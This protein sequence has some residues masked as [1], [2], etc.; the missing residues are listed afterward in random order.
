M[1]L[2]RRLVFQTYVKPKLLAKG[3]TASDVMRFQKA[4]KMSDYVTTEMRMDL[5]VN[6]GKQGGRCKSLR[7]VAQRRVASMMARGKVASSL[8]PHHLVP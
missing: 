4:F 1:Q 2:E 7:I 5:L 6:Q 3:C 8:S